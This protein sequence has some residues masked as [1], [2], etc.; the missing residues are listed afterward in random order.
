MSFWLTRDSE[1]NTFDMSNWAWATILAIAEV[2]G[3]EP[4]GTVFDCWEE[5]G[6]DGWSGTYMTND[7]QTVTSEDALNLASALSKSAADDFQKLV[8]TDLE[9]V[10]ENKRGLASFVENVISY[11]KRGSFRLG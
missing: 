9:S 6:F 3:W 10:L 11:F 1:E 8:G 7:C 4:L 2:Y 5:Y